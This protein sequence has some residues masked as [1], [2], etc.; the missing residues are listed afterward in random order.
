M[1]AHKLTRREMVARFFSRLH[2][3]RLRIVAEVRN[4]PVILVHQRHAGEQVR[5]NHVAVLVNAE[6]AGRRQSLDKVDVLALERKT[7][8][9][10]VGA[11]GDREDRLQAI[12]GGAHI[13]DDP[14]RA[15]QLTGFRTLSAEGPDVFARLVVLIDVTRSVPV[16]HIDIAVWSDGKIRRAVFDLLAIRVRFIL[17]RLVGIPDRKDLFAI[18][19]GLYD[20]AAFRVAEVQE[21]VSALLANMQPMRA[22]P[23][24]LAPGFHEFTLM[25]EYDHAVAAFA[26]GI[27]RVVNINIGVRIFADA[28]SVAVFDIGGKL[29]PIVG[30]FVFMG[31]LA[32]NGLGAAGF[33]VR[34]QNQWRGKTREK[35]TPAML[36]FRHNKN[37]II[38][39]YLAG[40]GGSG[41]GRAKILPC[42]AGA[43]ST[44]NIATPL[45]IGSPTS[46]PLQTAL[47]DL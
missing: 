13:H 16:A 8:K 17:L 29:A 18:E 33:I 11:V 23:E 45:T 42:A 31:A 43:P 35:R 25:I 27:H 41:M 6:M 4:Y 47:P 26:R 15:V 37:P 46:V 32:Q 7:L 12:R 38:L 1:R 5:H 34:A 44:A 28:V 30:D 39:R 24:V 40:T 21:F 3:R 36:R 9:P 10:F 19:R 14:M 20:K 2:V 22:A